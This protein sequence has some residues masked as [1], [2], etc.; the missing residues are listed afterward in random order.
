MIFRGL[1]KIRL[2]KLKWWHGY[3]FA[4]LLGL[5]IGSILTLSTMRAEDTKMRTELL[6]R[7]QTIEKALDWAMV[8]RQSVINVE[9][10]EWQQLKTKLQHVCAATSDCRW[11]YL[12]YQDNEHHIRFIFDT[13][14]N[15]DPNYSPPD[16]IY[17]DATPELSLHFQTHQDFVEGPVQDAWGVWVSALVMHE[18]LGTDGF[19]VSLGVDVDAKKWR[20]IVNRSAFTPIAATAAYLVLIICLLLI[21]LR[22][23]LKKEKIQFT[24]DQHYINAN[25]DKLTGLANR[26]LFEDVMKKVGYAAQRTSSAFAVLFMDLDG[27]KLANDTHGHGVGDMILIAVAKRIT[28][29]IRLEDTVARYGGDEFI[30]LLPRLQN[31]QQAQMVAQKLIASLHE[32]IVVN[33]VSHQ[34]SISIGLAIFPIDTEDTD[35][36]ISMADQAMYLAKREGKNQVKSYSELSIPK[37]LL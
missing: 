12:M 3:V 6:Q 22:E 37:T 21:H 29:T 2:I 9:S 11:M 1:Q 14:E 23:L 35:Q 8:E 36:L 20:S 15:D 5:G 13:L 33:G 16:S 28:N 17:D 10:P 34:L 30:V 25:Y 19:N 18:K 32:P 26:T 27:F 24:A 31:K 4:I 7:L